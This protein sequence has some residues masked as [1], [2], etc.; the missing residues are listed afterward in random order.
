MSSVTIRSSRPTSGIWERKGREVE[1]TVLEHTVLASA[2]PALS[3]ASRAGLRAGTAEAST[4]GLLRRSACCAQSRGRQ[5][6][7]QG[8]ARRKHTGA[9]PP[10]ATALPPSRAPPARPRP[11]PPTGARPSRRAARLTPTPTGKV[12]T[13]P[14]QTP[15]RPSTDPRLCQPR[16]AR[17]RLPQKLTRCA[18]YSAALPPAS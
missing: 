7:A 9:T 2:V 5:R 13:D 14:L 18:T 15:Y 17:A 1:H 12:L 6:R 8:L 10:P 16:P 11:P 4:V 3:S